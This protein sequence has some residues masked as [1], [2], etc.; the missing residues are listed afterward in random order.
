MSYFLLNHVN[1]A[2]PN[3]NIYDPSIRSKQL[4]LA[5]DV[6]TM[7]EEKIIYLQMKRDEPWHCYN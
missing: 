4:K 7:Y 6:H 5:H 1:L 3:R 2:R